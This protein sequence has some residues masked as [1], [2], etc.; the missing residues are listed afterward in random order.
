M[1]EPGLEPQISFF[2]CK[3]TT[4][5]PHKPDW[6][7][8]PGQNFSLEILIVEPIKVLCLINTFHPVKWIIVLQKNSSKWCSVLQSESLYEGDPENNVWL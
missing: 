6:N 8:D 3:H 4:I 7:P 5:A 2:Q 1:S